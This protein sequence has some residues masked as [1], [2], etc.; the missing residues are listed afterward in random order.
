MKKIIRLSESDLTRL[1]MRVINEGEE[2]LKIYY[3]LVEK[4]FNVLQAYYLSQLDDDTGWY[5]L[6][7]MYGDS[8]SDQLFDSDPYKFMDFAYKDKSDNEMVKTYYPKW[9][10]NGV[11]SMHLVLLRYFFD[12]DN[13]ELN[14]FYKKY[15]EQSE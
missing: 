10:K 4:G 7:H 13:G 6:F 2:H 14:D 9:T 11:A 8:V 3:D 15:K 12:G 5:N 1:V